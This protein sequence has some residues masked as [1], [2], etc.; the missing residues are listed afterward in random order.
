M[1]DKVTCSKCKKETEI[2]KVKRHSDHDEI[3]LK[4]GDS[5]ILNKR[6]MI[7]NVAVSD[8]LTTYVISFNTEED[9]I[10]GFGIL[11]RSRA[12]FHGVGRNKFV[13]QKE[14]YN[15]L[16]NSHVSFKQIEQS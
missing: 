12:R 6:D 15:L 14:Q 10:K 8:K 2:L 16:K 4:C 11:A 13:I 1:V 9:R 3:V 7:E 5:Y